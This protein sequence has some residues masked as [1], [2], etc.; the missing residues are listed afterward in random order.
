[1][2]FLI[3]CGLV[4][5]KFMDNLCA[6]IRRYLSSA[7]KVRTKPEQSKPSRQGTVAPAPTAVQLVGR[8]G[9]GMLLWL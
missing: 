4:R 6:N 3:E 9:F 5:T 2:C 7:Q 1:M 8:G